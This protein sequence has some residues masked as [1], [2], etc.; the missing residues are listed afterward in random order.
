MI[1]RNIEQLEDYILHEYDSKF[2]DKTPKSEQEL[3]KKYEQS[4]YLYQYV[5]ARIDRNAVPLNNEIRAMF[6]H[7]AEYR[8]IDESMV[9]TNL[10]KA[11]G[12]FRRLNIDSFKLICDEFDKSLYQTLIKEYKYDYRN[13]IKGY[14]KEF[15]EMYICARNLYLE[16]QKMERVGCDSGVHNVIELYHNAAK[17][18][19]ELKKY[20]VKHK[21]QIKNIYVSAIAKKSIQL[22]ITVF[23]IIVTIVG[24]IMP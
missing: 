9:K 10:S 20:Y 21:D 7:I 13:V 23:G 17:K 15:G 24:Y 18:Y 3:M 2:I 8:T 22:F 6:G 14:L 11:Y 5:T 1:I 4:F 16:A 12:H 19:L